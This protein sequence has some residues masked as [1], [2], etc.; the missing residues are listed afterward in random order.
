MTLTEQ[1]TRPGGVTATAPTRSEPLSPARLALGGDDAVT[2]AAQRLGLVVTFDDADSHVDVL[3]SL[4]LANFIDG[5]Q[6]WAF[7]RRLARVR[8]DATLLPPGTVPIRYASDDHNV[9]RLAVGDGWTLR[10]VRWQAGGA[11]VSVTAVSEELGRS[12]V[13]VAV[14]GAEVEPEPDADEV[15]VGFW[16]TSG[17]G[18]RRRARPISANPWPEIR[19][20]YTP[21]AA[22]AFDALMALDGEQLNGR[23]LL[24]HGPPGTGKTT[25]LRSLAWAWR[26][27]CQLDF[28]VDPERLFASP[29][30]LIEVIMG[31]SDH[32][33]KP[34]HLLLLE[35]CDELVRGG[36]KQ[37]AGQSLSRLLN[38]TD[39]LL[40]Q[41][42]NVLVAIT[43]NEDIGKLHPAVTR[44]GRCLG[45]I[46]VGALP[47]PQAVAW[48][49]T[50]TAVPAGGATLAQLL[51][52]RDGTV[53]VVTAEAVPTGGF[54]L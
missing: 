45:Q 4:I 52:L 34:W 47:Y 3:D 14:A 7:T 37:S 41:G 12:I 6:P 40:G 13:D 29:A 26:Q 23:I 48:L 43:T 19:R 21:A 17:N 32:D 9:A 22:G 50:S 27:W 49:G 11:M 25:A 31:A 36:A 15:V 28:V 38:L 18:P 30:Y 46:E 33:A 51:A 8:D 1:L 24:V 53:P 35:D 54:Y 42:R 10:S 39:G 16:H 20:N 5:S 44:P 2:A